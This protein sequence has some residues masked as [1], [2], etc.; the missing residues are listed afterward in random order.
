MKAVEGHASEIGK[1]EAV[2]ALKLQPILM[3]L[4]LWLD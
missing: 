2:W 1:L 3:Q 4:S